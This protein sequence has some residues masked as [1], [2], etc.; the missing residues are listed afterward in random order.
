MSGRGPVATCAGSSGGAEPPREDPPRLPS[1]CESAAPS[2]PRK[3]KG[4]GPAKGKAMLREIADGGKI[5]VPFDKETMTYKGLSREG[6]W[7]D[8]AV[9][10]LIRKHLEPYHDMW[11]QIPLHHRTEIFERLL[12][13]FDIDFTHDNGVYRDMMERD[14]KRCYKKWKSDLHDHFKQNGG[15]ADPD[16]VRA[17]VPKTVR[18]PGHW[19]RCCKRFS[20][21]KFLKKSAT[22]SS[23]RAKKLSNS[24]QGRIPYARHRAN[25][26]DPETQVPK[27]AIDNWKE[28]NPDAEEIHRLLDERVAEAAPNGLMDECDILEETL[29]LGPRRGHMNG[30]GPSLPRRV[31]PA[32]PAVNMFQLVLTDLEGRLQQPDAPEAQLRALITQVREIIEGLAPL[33]Q[34][35]VAAPPPP[36]PPETDV[37]V[38]DYDD[39]NDDTDFVI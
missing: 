26:T 14:A 10:I 38:N 12:D 32:Q 15:L 28:L 23:N 19:R 29:G 18:H 6:T 37:D 8:S 4:R 35:R 20:S 31:P 30:V 2:A 34:Q 7:Y 13:W 24:K 17:S 5:R 33:L 27:S 16:R 39:D 9:G 25:K 36:P 1:Y 3:R 21:A 22:N 11:R